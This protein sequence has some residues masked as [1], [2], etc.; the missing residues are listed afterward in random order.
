MWNVITALKEILGITQF[1]QLWEQ[2]ATALDDE[3]DADASF[4]AGPIERFELPA[5]RRGCRCRTRKSASVSL[6]LSG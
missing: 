4:D 2:L 3:R 1:E 5:R 6:R